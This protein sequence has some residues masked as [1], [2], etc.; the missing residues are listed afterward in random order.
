MKPTSMSR[1]RFCL[2]IFLVL[3]SLRVACQAAPAELETLRFQFEN[4]LATHFAERTAGQNAAA[5]TYT[6]ALYRVLFLSAGPADSPKSQAL[7]IELARFNEEKTPPSA[8]F[9]FP[10][11]DPLAT[12]F[13][14]RCQ[15]LESAEAK[16]TLDLAGKY[17][18]R[19]GMLQAQLETSAAGT[20]AR[21]VR[22]EREFLKSSCLVAQAKHA[23]SGRKK[24]LMQI[25]APM[26][27]AVDI[28]FSSQYTWSKPHNLGG[29]VNTPRSDYGFTTS[30]D[31]CVA[32]FT[33]KRMDNVD[34]FECQRKHKS[35]PFGPARFLSKINTA[36]DESDACLS[37][38]GLVLVFGATGGPEHRG[39]WDVYVSRRNSTADDWAPKLNLGAMINAGSMEGYPTLGDGGRTLVVSTERPGGFGRRDL[40]TSQRGEDPMAWSP[41]RNMGDP[42]NSKDD[43]VQCCFL[44]DGHSLLFTRRYDAQ[45][46]FVAVLDD[47][48]GYGLRQLPLPRS[49]PISN[50]FFVSHD[51][52]TIY[53]SAELPGGFGRSDVW[54]MR[55]VLKSQQPPANAPP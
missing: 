17:D 34:L 26:L 48:G 10:E 44:G 15:E 1:F 51:F 29:N 4:G 28:L 39:S 49:I 41:L 14:R 22:D 12:G 30:R 53:F 3:P 32:I 31:E 19:L 18:Q 20:E 23:V 11:I 45:K 52:L 8:P 7:K 38:D 16:A 46:A 2:A 55:R 13:L 24:S 27:G 40:W 42:F 33:S 43:D 35:E 6:N 54:C 36:G 21:T 9:G 25:G 37:G 50:P 47:K 5:A